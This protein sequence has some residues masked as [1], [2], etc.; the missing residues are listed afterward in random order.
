MILTKSLDSV[1]GQASKVG[2]L[3]FMINTN[4]E[5]NGTEIAGTVDLSHVKCNTALQELSRH[6]LIVFR[7]VGKSNLYRLRKE[8]ILYTDILRPLFD[9]EANLFHV[10]SGIIIKSFNGARPVTLAVFG[11]N[12]KGTALPDSDI[13]LLVIIPDSMPLSTAVKALEKAEETVSDKFGNQLSPLIVKQ[14]EFRKQYKRKNSL[15]SEIIKSNK[16]IY[17]KTV[18]EIL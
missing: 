18:A 5:M 11:S 10:L 9:R 12:V 17:G 15:Y 14:G 8:H 16:I 3:R 6:G 2:I 7:K 1:L 4:A 13:D